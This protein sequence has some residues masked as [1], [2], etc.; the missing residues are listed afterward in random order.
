MNNF[1]KHNEAK[2]LADCHSGYALAKQVLELREEN[3]SLY[4]LLADI[5]TAAGDA[6]G[7]LTQGEFVAHIAKTRKDL[8]EAQRQLASMRSV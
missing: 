2:S 4:Q 7:R 8:A 5:R 3:D 1:E 6:K